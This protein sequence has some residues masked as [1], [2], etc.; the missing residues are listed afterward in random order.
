ML[1]LL[2]SIL[3]VMISFTIIHAEDNKTLKDIDGFIKLLIREKAPTLEEYA[4][5]AGECGGERELSFELNECKMNNW[6]YHS[7]ECINYTKTRCLNANNEVALS[8]K[9]IRNKFLTVGK[10]YQ[11]HKIYLSNDGFTHKI[12][13]VKIGKDCFKLFYNYNLSLNHYAGFLIDIIEVNGLKISPY[14]QK[15]I[16]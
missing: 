14:S 6:D 10:K 1:K 3:F 7:K 4:K 11:V 13:E 2:C 16:K 5:Y 12:I 9:W 8:L 15:N